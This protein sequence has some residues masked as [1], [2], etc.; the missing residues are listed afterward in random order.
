M[1]RVTFPVF[2]PPGTQFPRGTAEIAVAPDG[3]GVVFVAVA[4]NGA[5]QLWL[6]RFDAADSGVLV[7]TGGSHNP[8]WSPDARWIGFFTRG[9][10]MKVSRTGGEPQVLCDARPYGYG[11]WNQ[12]GTIVFSGY[13][14]ALNRVSENGGGVRPVTVLD[15][16]R[17]E[18]AH[19]FPV[20]LP[21]GQRF[22]YLAVKRGADSSELFQGSLDSTETRRVF[23]SEANVSVA[24]RYL[25]SLNK[26]VLV[27][28]PYSPDRG[29]V[30]GVPIEI[31]DRIL[32]DPPRR[33]GGP[34][35]VGGSVIAYRSAS[36]NS[37]LLW[38]D[39]AGRAAGSRSPPQEIT[40]TPGC[41]PTRG[42]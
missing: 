3:S 41:R 4:A 26:G 36:P 16:S 13:G 22:L 30:T 9:K 6:R 23:A 37:R 40:I 15:E 24:G 27:A 2:A 31:A 11:T 17:E 5:R 39:R 14:Q 20:F 32:S 7:G 38:F 28:Q 1:S 35:S 21:D 8:F 34:F 29:A 12:G 10:L 18:F 33:S 25:I 19:S 42:R